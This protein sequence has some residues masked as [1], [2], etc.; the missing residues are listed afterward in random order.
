MWQ[1]ISSVKKGNDF[2]VPSQ[3]VASQTLSGLEKAGDG[4][5]ANFFYS[6]P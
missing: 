6:V 4:K 2:S 5:I 3:D 1:T